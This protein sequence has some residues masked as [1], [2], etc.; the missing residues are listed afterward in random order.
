MNMW[1]VTMLRKQYFSHFNT[2]ESWLLLITYN[3]YSV[4]LLQ[5]VFPPTTAV[6]LCYY[7]MSVLKCVCVF[8]YNISILRLQ[9]VPR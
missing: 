7:D 9:F 2:F 1:L 8:E 6:Q 3:Y 4:V 5:I